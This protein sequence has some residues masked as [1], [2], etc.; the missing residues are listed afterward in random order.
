M[1]APT[2]RSGW[3]APVPPTVAIEIAAG[4][5]T[6]AELS[7]GSG[8]PVVSAFATE[9]VPV[10]A[11]VPALV[12]TNIVEP[13]V[14]AEALKRAL[15]ARRTRIA[16]SRRPCGAR[17]RRACV[18]PA[19]RAAAWPGGR[20]RSAHPLAAA[21][22]HTVSDR[23]GAGQPFPG[24]RGRRQCHARGRR[25]ATRRHRAVRGGHRPARHSRGHRRSRELQRHERGRRRGRG[26]RRRLAAGLSCGGRDDASRSCAARS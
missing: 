6:V 23:R 17:Q 19:L 14:V 2:R 1:S 24:E 13:D 12:G 16:A 3:F 15:D 8:G 10:A 7:G 4:R 21:Q 5:V 18:A 26:A 11:V 22:G 9:T 20:S 25:C